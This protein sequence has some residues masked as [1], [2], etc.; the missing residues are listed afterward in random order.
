MS[1]APTVSASQCRGDSFD[2]AGTE[3]KLL[4]HFEELGETSPYLADNRYSTP[5]CADRSAERRCTALCGE[6]S[7]VT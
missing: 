7:T 2:V 4:A 3:P 1:L 6:R 5:D